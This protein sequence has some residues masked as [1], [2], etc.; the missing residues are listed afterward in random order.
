V[1]IF[2]RSPP[3][4]SP[5]EW[6]LKPTPLNAT[7][8]LMRAEPGRKPQGNIEYRFWDA[9]RAFDSGWVKS[10][11]FTSMNLPPGRVLNV[12]LAMRDNA[13]NTGKPSAPIKLTMPAKQPPAFQF[14]GERCVIEAE[15]FHDK[16]DTAESKW[17]PVK[18]D[19]YS[20]GAAIETPDGE[21]VADP[22]AI[23]RG[24]APRLDYRVNFPKPGNYRLNARAFAFHDGNN[25]FYLGLDFSPRGQRI[26][27]QPGAVRWSNDVELEI[28]NPGIHLVHIWMGK[29]GAVFDALC[30]TS[31]PKQL[32][33][34]ES[35]MP[36][37][38]SPQ[39]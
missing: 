36:A 28:T 13:G 15:H 19:T 38:E 37:P 30:V 2:D 4:P 10:P 16:T 18:K 29:D 5:A 33:T 17:V 8:V 27:L 3:Q 21:R 32:P 12:A 14:Q 1:P 25:T 7:T 26:D 24:E 34:G 6:Q 23:E 31:D 39:K 35:T 20:G 22:V 9:G 11:V